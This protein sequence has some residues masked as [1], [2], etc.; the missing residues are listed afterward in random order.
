MVINSTVS[1][2]TLSW[3]AVTNNS[4]YEVFLVYDSCN[5]SNMDSNCLKI[6]DN[7][8]TT[9]TTISDLLSNMEYIFAVRA[10]CMSTN[11]SQP[12]NLS[13]RVTGITSKLPFA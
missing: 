2:I 9:M 5:G 4:F 10:I 13:E 3:E 11:D 1:E 7:V 6:H 12:S 8:T